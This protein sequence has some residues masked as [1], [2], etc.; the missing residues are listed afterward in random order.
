MS[1]IHIQEL[2]RTWQ[3]LSRTHDPKLILMPTTWSVDKHCMTNHMRSNRDL[4]QSQAHPLSK[5]PSLVTGARAVKFGLSFWGPEIPACLHTTA[6]KKEGE[7]GERESTKEKNWE[8]RRKGEK[9]GCLRRGGASGA[10]KKRE[11]GKTIFPS[12]HYVEVSTECFLGFSS[13]YQT[14]SLE[15][16]KK[17]T[18][19]DFS[20]NYR[21]DHCGWSDIFTELF[22]LL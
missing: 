8:R 20:R 7:E 22:T 6:C 3:T 15:I 1:S 19:S 13:H 11:T 12:F 17:N 5:R 16:E 21:A 10:E 9:G 2:H 4:L 14:Y 18:L